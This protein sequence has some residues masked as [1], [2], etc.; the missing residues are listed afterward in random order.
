MRVDEAGRGPSTLNPQP[1]TLEAWR[2]AD[3]GRRALSALDASEGRRRRRKRDTTPDAI[4]MGIKR[5]LLERLAAEDP[6]PE[7]FEAWL[8]QQ[9][10]A[11]PASGPVRALCAEMLSEYRF[12]GADPTFRRWLAEGAP[13]ADADLE[14][15]EIGPTRVRIPIQESPP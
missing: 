9:V 13:S 2:P 12:A 4:G 10:T 3:F 14:P 11:A 7:R 15:S 6:P 5:D 8:L 1:S